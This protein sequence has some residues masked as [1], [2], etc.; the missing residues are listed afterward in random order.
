M[1]RW[2]IAIVLIAA[3]VLA[4]AS[5][6]RAQTPRTPW[7][8]PDLQGSYTNSNESGIPM[9]RPAEFAGKTLA[10]ITPAELARVMQ[11][12][13]Q[14]TEKTAAVIGGTAENDTGAGPSH[15]YENYNAKNSRAWMISRSA[16]WADARADARSGAARGR[17][18]RRPPWRGRLL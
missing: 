9:Q 16:R 4:A 2:N 1:G 3:S 13:H 14:Q 15:W 18:A 8:D 7:G 17:R 11:Q 10:E 6:A 12:R 5:A